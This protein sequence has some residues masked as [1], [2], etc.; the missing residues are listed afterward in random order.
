MI[1]AIRWGKQASEDVSICLK[2]EYPWEWWWHVIEMLI[3]TEK[4]LLT[5]LFNANSK[6][7]RY[8]W[9][10]CNDTSLKSY[11]FWASLSL[12]ILT[13]LVIS[14]QSWQKI[15]VKLELRF[16]LLCYLSTLHFANQYKPA[17]KR[18]SLSVKK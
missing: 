1:D 16:H 14:H 17:Q 8:L 9:K 2:I 11:K 12:I 15:W 3:E 5:H 7:L 18:F 6:F 13:F 4:F 10:S